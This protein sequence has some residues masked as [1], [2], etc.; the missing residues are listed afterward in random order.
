MKQWNSKTT[1]KQ[2]LP[3]CSS[4]RITDWGA[5]NKQVQEFLE[6]TLSHAPC[7]SLMKKGISPSLRKSSK[8]KLVELAKPPGGRVEGNVETFL[9]SFNTI[10]FHLYVRPSL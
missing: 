7:V 6:P 3:T 5:K 8:Q 4:F 10:T 2:S 9:Y 1:S